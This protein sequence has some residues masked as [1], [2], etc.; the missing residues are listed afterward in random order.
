MAK[1][2]IIYDATQEIEQLIKSIE[3]HID[4]K[5]DEKE[6]FDS[7][8]KLLQVAFDEGRKFQKQINIAAASRDGICFKSEI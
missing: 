4:L 2:Q 7:A 5:Q 1:L 8:Q 3:K 6:T